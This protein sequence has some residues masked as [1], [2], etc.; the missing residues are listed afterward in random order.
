MIP[1]NGKLVKCPYCGTRKELMSIISGNT[2]NGKYWSDS[3]TFF[4]MLPQAS[5]VQ[6]C[7]NCGKYFL[8][9]KQESIEGDNYSSELGELTYPEWKEAYSQFV[10][11]SAAVIQHPLTGVTHQDLVNVRCWLIWA[12][13]DHFYRNKKAKPSQEEY[14][15]FCSVVKDFIDGFDWSGIQVPL[16]KAE[17]YR[18]ANEMEKCAEVLNAISYDQLED[19][20]K[21][22]YDGIKRRMKKNNTV[23]FRLYV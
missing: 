17:F 13:N 18:E 6:K 19:F 10:R 3:K 15:F 8:K 5:P 7:P 23:V 12:Y 14:A 22:I 9:N 2:F 21:G 16:L 20:E 1:G 4:P 11:I